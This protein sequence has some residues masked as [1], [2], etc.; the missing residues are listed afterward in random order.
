MKTV[1][2]GALS[3]LSLTMGVSLLIPAAQAANLLIND[4]VEGQITLEHDANWEFG[5]ISNGTPFGPDV[6]GSTTVPGE[7]ASFSGAWEVNTGGV[8]DPGT[9][10]IYIVDQG[11]P[12]LVRATIT[13]T[14]STVVQPGF[15][16]ATISVAVQSS[17]C[18]S[19][20]GPL[21][22]AFAGLGITEP[23]GPIGIQGAFRNPATAAPVSIPSNLTIQYDAEADTDC[24]G[25]PNSADVCPDT[26]LPEQNVP[27]VGLGTNRFALTDDDDVFDTTAPRGKGPRKSFTLQDTAGCSCEQI[28]AALGLGEGH[29]KFG[30]S[31][32]A[33]EEWIDSL[34]P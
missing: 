12:N 17:P 14:W 28:I 7:S 9:G 25:V 19:N 27:S 4:T 10:V 18:G 32:S 31:I 8:P 30:C 20:L 13:A 21:P 6:A 23:N 1:M 24:D 11:N 34:T 29:V 2:V 26:V 16:R 22:P 5:A 3:A 15:D 33:M